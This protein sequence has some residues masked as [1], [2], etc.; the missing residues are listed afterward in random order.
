MPRIERSSDSPSDDDTNDYERDTS[1]H[2]PWRRA[3]NE[4]PAASKVGGLIRAEGA[5]NSQSAKRE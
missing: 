2:S 1:K 3:P 4:W 5:S